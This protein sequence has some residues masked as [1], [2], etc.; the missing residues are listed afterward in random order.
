MDATAEAVAASQAKDMQRSS[1]CNCIVNF[2]F[3]EG[4]LLTTFELLHELVEDGRHDQAIRLCDFFSDP[5]FPPDLISL[6]NSLRVAD[7]Q[8]LLEE[9][10]VAEEKLA[11]SEYELRLAQED[12]TKLQSKLQKMVES[13]VV[14]ESEEL[15]SENRADLVNSLKNKLQSLVGQHVDVLES[16]TP[17]VRKRVEGSFILCSIGF[18]LVFS[19]HMRFRKLFGDSHFDVA[20]SFQK[21]DLLLC[22]GKA[23]YDF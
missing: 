22:F 9:K 14:I 13:P 16:L 2:F 7:P 21:E 8:T 23:E 6:F 17:T 15:S 1:L 12:L 18:V 11:I 19:F 3:Q 4:Y 10:I 5:L 20:C